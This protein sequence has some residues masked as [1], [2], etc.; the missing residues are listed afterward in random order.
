MSFKVSWP[1]FSDDF[2]TQASQ[3]LT[4]AL[5]KGQKPN[6]IVGDIEVADLNMGTKPPDL[7]ILEIGELGEDRFK[8]VFKMTYAGDAHVILNTKVQANPLNLPRHEYKISRRSTILAANHPLVVPMRLRI[9]NLRLKGIIVLVIDKTKGTTLVFKN[10]PLEKVDVNSTFDGVAS[11]RRFLQS[12]IEGQLRQMFKEDLPM[13]IH[14]LSLV[15]IQQKEGAAATNSNSTSTSSTTST[16]TQSAENLQSLDAAANLDFPL[17]TRHPQ[18]HVHHLSEET[19]H[20]FVNRPHHQKWS[21]NEPVTVLDSEYDAEEL[22][23][24]N[25]GAYVLHKSL[26]PDDSPLG[27]EVVSE[28]IMILPSP[29]AP[30]LPPAATSSTTST[31]SSNI[32]PLES[33]SSK[34]RLTATRISTSSPGSIAATSTSALNLSPAGNQ[35]PIPGRQT[36][37]PVAELLSTSPKSPPLSFD[38]PA[39]S[40][41]TAPSSILSPRSHTSTGLRI[42]VQISHPINHFLASSGNGSTTSTTRPPTYPYSPTPNQDS[43]ASSSAA[44]KNRH[45]APLSHHRHPSIRTKFGSTSSS[46]RSSVSPSSPHSAGIVHRSS[47]SLHNEPVSRNMSMSSLAAGIAAAAVG[48]AGAVGDGKS[49]V[50]SGVYGYGSG[51]SRQRYAPTP[52]SLSFHSLAGV[53]GAGGGGGGGVGNR[54]R[55]SSGPSSDDGIQFK[56]DG[57]LAGGGGIPIPGSNG[58]HHSHHLRHHHANGG[59]TTNNTRE[60]AE[61]PV[62]MTERVIL[63]PSDNQVT[64]HLASLMLANHTISPVMHRL[65]HATFRTGGGMTGALL[66]SSHLSSVALGTSGGGGQSLTSA[67]FVGSTNAF[68]STS[69]MGSHRASGVSLSLA[70]RNDSGSSFASAASTTV[71]TTTGNKDAAPMS[72]PVGP[73]SGIVN[74]GTLSASSTPFS[75]ARKRGGARNVRKLTLPSNI[76]AGMPRTNSSGGIFGSSSPSSAGAGAAR[77]ASS[78]GRSF[79]TSSS[80]SS[81]KSSVKLSS[82][83]VSVGDGGAMLGR[84]DSVLESPARRST[85]LRSMAAP[86]QQRIEETSESAD[87]GV[88]VVSDQRAG[89]GISSGSGAGQAS[90]GAK[91]LSIGMMRRSSYSRG[92]N[93]TDFPDSD[94]SSSGDDNGRITIHAKSPPTNAGFLSRASF[95]ALVMPLVSSSGGAGDPGSAGSTGGMEPVPPRSTSS[96]STRSAGSVATITAK[97]VVRVKSNASSMTITP[98]SFPITPGSFPT[99]D[100]NDNS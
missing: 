87:E 84:G 71:N 3:Q 44:P 27:L 39:A 41:A 9:S 5:N 35:S 32:P 23:S 25:V 18:V 13:L 61:P 81:S 38:A 36:L 49:G 69:M 16:A 93:S 7:E 78:S 68:S 64:A 66:P 91:S 99:T 100:Y 70:H 65:E 88:H 96:M 45:S 56:T 29:L 79:G 33:K 48:G 60:P 94:T 62:I 20:R 24:Q 46:M 47:V 15:L 72:P 22:E 51:S 10:D 37:E 19:V 63:Q 8:G 52:H 1:R 21:G 85:A 42:P 57:N 83:L 98:G 95:G 31:P 43:I 97:K 92:M 59:N 12:Q 76:A 11:V 40:T 58:D 28:N 54:S 75:S 73:T 55:G 82:P 53:G 77:T 74:G 30:P 86:H 89:G 67:G 50:S 6:N 2:I 34:S 4:I 14:K 80:I 90:S 26:N 17:S